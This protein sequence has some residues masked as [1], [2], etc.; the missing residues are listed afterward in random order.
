MD[1]DLCL[2]LSEVT[3]ICR[4]PQ[5]LYDY[6]SHG[7]SISRSQQDLQVT[8]SQRA[9]ENA[10]QRRGLSDRYAIKVTHA[11][12]GTCQF[13]LE[14]LKPIPVSLITSNARNSA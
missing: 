9:I 5:P 12:I 3:G 10:L 4:L 1:Y 2:K 13:S 8:Y 14:K 11:A 7:Q 6:R